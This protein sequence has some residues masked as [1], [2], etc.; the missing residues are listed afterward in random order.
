[1]RFTQHESSNF[2]TVMAAESFLVAPTARSVTS[3]A[4]LES[5]P[6]TDLFLS[7]VAYT[8]TTILFAYFF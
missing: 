2:S 1:M 4:L 3:E 6:L 5:S 8:L 7:Q